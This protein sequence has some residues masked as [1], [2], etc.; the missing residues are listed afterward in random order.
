MAQR[1]AIFQADLMSWALGLETL[2]APALHH[3]L[4]TAMACAAAGFRG[5]RQKEAPQHACTTVGLCRV[6]PQ[7]MVPA[8][9]VAKPRTETFSLSSHQRH[10]VYL[11]A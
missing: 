5:T 7:G 3:V 1:R 11:K 8:G 10:H 9:R 2:P 4:P 6:Q